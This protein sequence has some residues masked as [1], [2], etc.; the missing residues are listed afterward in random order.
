MGR[1]RMGHDRLARD[2]TGRGLGR[3]RLAPP[4]QA[5]PSVAACIFSRI[6]DS[7]KEC[8]P[9]RPSELLEA[10]GRDRWYGRWRPICAFGCDIIADIFKGRGT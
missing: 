9:S 1:D 8:P 7:T 10:E 5:R 4:T 2:V 6:A 3:D